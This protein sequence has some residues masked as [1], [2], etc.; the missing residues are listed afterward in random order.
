MVIKGIGR[1]QKNNVFVQ[2]FKLLNEH[3]LMKN[4][5]L[6]VTLA[7]RSFSNPFSN[8]K[9]AGEKRLTYLI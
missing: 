1:F 5:R 3:P 2:F 8:D 6:N 4:Y 7:F 9:I